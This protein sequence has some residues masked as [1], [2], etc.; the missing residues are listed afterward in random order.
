M[1]AP[2]L[3]AVEKTGVDGR[4]ERFVMLVVDHDQAQRGEY[5][6]HSGEEM[7]EF[8]LVQLLTAIGLSDIAIAAAIHRA[9][10]RFGLLE[11]RIQ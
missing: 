11:G 8:E 7:G 1:A 9:R 4:G 10:E 5:L 2:G 3:W 6:W